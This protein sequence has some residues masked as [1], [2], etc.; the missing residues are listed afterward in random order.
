MFTAGC[1][2]LPPPAAPGD[3]PARR[4]ELQALGNWNLSGRVAIAAGAEGFSGGL[5]WRQRGERAE[6]EL[7]GPMGGAAFLV[8]VDGADYVV[9]DER[10]A[11]V[12][13]EDARRFVR[14]KTGAGAPLPIAAMRYWLIGV[15][16]PDAP[17]RE[18]IGEDHRLASLEQS[19][20]QV[21]FDRYKSAGSVAMPERIEITTVGLRLRVLVA[22]WR[23]EP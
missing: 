4:A 22:D 12:S 5:S 17:H 13:G 9:T 7:R 23:I 16:A 19:G 11:T 3:W 1:A 2:T 8:H 21:R 18:T 14:E 15:P 20:W 6:I 10:G